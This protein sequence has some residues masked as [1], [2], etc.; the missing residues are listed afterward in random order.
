MRWPARPGRAVPRPAAATSSATSTSPS[1]DVP[2]VRRHQHVVE[3]GEFRQQV[4]ELED[5]AERAVAQ[6]VAVAG[7]AGCRCACRRGGSCPESGASSVPSRCRSVL[8]PDPDAP[9]MLR[10]SPVCTSRFR[11]LQ[12][13]HLDGVAAVGLVEVLGG[14]AWFPVRSWFASGQLRRSTGLN[15]TDYSNRSARTGCSRAARHAGSRLNTTAIADRA[16]VH[17]HHAQRVD[18]R[19][20][21]LEVV[22]VAR[23]Q[24]L[25][26]Q[27]ASGTAR[28]R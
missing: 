26:G 25:A 1:V 22:D 14:R 7:R 12:H 28:S 17:Q 16:E 23:E 5:V 21:F 18:V 8:L 4:V 2:D 6:Q 11:P 9:T 10:N 3:R 27:S 13:P 24:R 15:R 19:R 20:D